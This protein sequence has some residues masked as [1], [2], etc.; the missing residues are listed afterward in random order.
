MQNPFG[1][2]GEK[3]GRMSP[4]LVPKNTL[5]GDGLTFTATLVIEMS[6]WLFDYA[7]RTWLIHGSTR[8]QLCLRA[9]LLLANLLSRHVT[10]GFPQSFFAPDYKN[11]KTKKEK[12]LSTLS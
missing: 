8:H 11:N 4:P 3:K 10:E 7:G 5:A 6:I 2:S 12:Q 1:K 9:L